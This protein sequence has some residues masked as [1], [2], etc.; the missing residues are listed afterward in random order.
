M[1]LLLIFIKQINNFVLHCE[2]FDLNIIRHIDSLQFDFIINDIYISDFM[3]F[4]DSYNIKI[5][6]YIKSIKSIKS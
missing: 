4:M 2:H 3:D 5:I 1:L 6:D